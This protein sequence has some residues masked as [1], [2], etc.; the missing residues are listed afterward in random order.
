M[1]TFGADFGALFCTKNQDPSY[2]LDLNNVC[3]SK[4]PL[5][6][7]ILEFG[8]FVADLIEKA[9]KIKMI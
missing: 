8:R 5:H 1:R 4:L 3:H 2:Q 7:I 9:R 6:A